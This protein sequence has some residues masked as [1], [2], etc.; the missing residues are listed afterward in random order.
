[1][2]TPLILYTLDEACTKLGISRD[3]LARWIQS[4][5]VTTRRTPAKPRLYCDPLE[6]DALAAGEQLQPGPCGILRTID[7]MHAE[8]YAQN[9][10]APTVE[11]ADSD[12][13]P[14]LPIAYDVG[15]DD[16]PDGPRPEQET[17][18]H[19]DTEI[20]VTRSSVR[21]ASL[22]AR[23]MSPVPHC[24]WPIAAQTLTWEEIKARQA[25]CPPTNDSDYP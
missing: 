8:D 13:Y 12:D 10:A 24:V 25:E 5:K 3:T 16:Y 7:R 4:G 14:E 6:I 1:M 9:A 17:A 21:R 23:G 2:N 15:L 19:D 22:H 11:Y 18:F 20:P